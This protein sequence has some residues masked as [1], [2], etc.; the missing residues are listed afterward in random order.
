MK[1]LLTLIIIAL[2]ISSCNS[3]DSK[4]GYLTKLEKVKEGLVG[5]WQCASNGAYYRYSKEGDH[6]AGWDFFDINDHK[7]FMPY[8][9]VETE[10]GYAIR[11]NNS[12]EYRTRIAMLTTDSLKLRLTRMDSTIVIESFVRL[13][14]PERD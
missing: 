1:P 12:R 3:Y 2:G 9:V 10:S 5:T 7:R 4:K 11:F 14:E 8:E 13:G 6:S